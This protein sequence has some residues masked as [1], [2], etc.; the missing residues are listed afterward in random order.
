MH[1]WIC[2]GCLGLKTLKETFYIE[3]MFIFYSSNSSSFKDSV[4]RS[5]SVVSY[6]PDCLQN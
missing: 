3:F 1:S 2:L 4:S 5:L 6:N